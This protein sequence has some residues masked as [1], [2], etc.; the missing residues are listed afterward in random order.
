MLVGAVVVYDE[1]EVEFWRC[2]GIDL[3]EEAEKFLMPVTGHAVTDHL[4][5]EHAE[6]RK[7]SGCSVAFIVVR[8]GAAAALLEW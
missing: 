4:A 6:R 5:I 8:H 1:V 2:L 7:K 3:L